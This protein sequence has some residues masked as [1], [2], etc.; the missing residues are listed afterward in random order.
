MDVTG[1]FLENAYLPYVCT[2]FYEKILRADDAT[3]NYKQL[4]PIDF[5]KIR[6]R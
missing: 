1:V 6:L 2:I 3:A 4:S 5:Y